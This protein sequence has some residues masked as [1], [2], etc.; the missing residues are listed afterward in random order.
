M[1]C[2]QEDT[3]R[4]RGERCREERGTEHVIDLQVLRIAAGR[5]E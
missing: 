4:P 2:K 3:M 1:S 5:L